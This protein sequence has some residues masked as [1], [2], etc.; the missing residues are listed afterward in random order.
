MIEMTFFF[1]N[2]IA[3]FTAFQCFYCN[4]S[5]KKRKDGRGEKER[6]RGYQVIAQVGYGIRKRGLRSIC[7]LS[8]VEG[9][10]LT[11]RIYFAALLALPMINGNAMLVVLP[12]YNNK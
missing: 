1:A 10:F 3:P 6:K 2:S 4:K 12:Y 9:K 11:P 8:G 5:D 7:W